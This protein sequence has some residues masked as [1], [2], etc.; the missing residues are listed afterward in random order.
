MRA[1]IVGIYLYGICYSE[2]YPFV[3]CGLLLRHFKGFPNLIH[4]VSAGYGKAAR[5]E[6]SSLSIVNTFG[7]L[8]AGG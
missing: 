7:S 6:R 5:V 4:R 3:R 8:R 2:V 1:R